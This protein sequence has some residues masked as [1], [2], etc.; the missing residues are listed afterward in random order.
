[1][2]IFSVLLFLSR[3]TT[4]PQKTSHLWNIHHTKALGLS[5]SN[6]GTH[7]VDVTIKGLRVF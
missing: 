6:E 1:M 3:E 5:C 4:F 7:G 2:Y